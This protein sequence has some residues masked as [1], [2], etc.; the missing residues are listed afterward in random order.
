MN[1][2]TADAPRIHII[3][4]GGDDCPPCVAWRSNELPKLRQT[5]AFRDRTPYPYERCVRIAGMGKCA[6]KG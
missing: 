4:M 5:K 1:A 2:Q 3:Y 6:V